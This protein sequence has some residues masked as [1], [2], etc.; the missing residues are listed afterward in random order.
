MMKS[1]KNT[2]KKYLKQNK[3]NKKKKKTK[4]DIKINQ[5]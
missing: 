4:S 5:N 3:G 1:E 2:I